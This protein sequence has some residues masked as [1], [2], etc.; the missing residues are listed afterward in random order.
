MQDWQAAAT[1]VDD[2]LREFRSIAIDNF[3]LTITFFRMTDKLDASNKPD[4]DYVQARN[5]QQVDRLTDAFKEK[6]LSNET[7]QRISNNE[8]LDECLIADTSRL[9]KLYV[10]EIV[11]NRK[12]ITHYDA[13]LIKECKQGTVK[14]TQNQLTR[15]EE[16]I[17]CVLLNDDLFRLIR[18]YYHLVLKDVSAESSFDYL[19]A[20]RVAKAMN[21]II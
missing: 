21:T 12:P 16:L 20:L 9:L 3:G 5:A 7:Y 8:E 17:R 4:W 19:N 13:E 18:G 11:N 14:L 10:G 2:I 1:H 15:I 6:L